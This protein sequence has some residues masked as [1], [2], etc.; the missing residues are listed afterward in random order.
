LAIAPR[1]SKNSLFFRSDK[2]VRYGSS[3]P[4]TRAR[5]GSTGKIYR[6]PTRRTQTAVATGS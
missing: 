2:V 6:R 5:F 1:G 4:A 3:W